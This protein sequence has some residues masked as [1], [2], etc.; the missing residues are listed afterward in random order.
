MQTKFE[1]E[2]KKNDETMAKIKDTGAAKNTL[3]V[4][5]I[6]HQEVLM[7]ENYKKNER[8]LRSSNTRFIDFSKKDTTEISSLKDEEANQAS[9][10]KDE[11]DK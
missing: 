5:T 8:A 7:R 6:K 3:A 11:T 9:E 4:D 10:I 1:S 2:I